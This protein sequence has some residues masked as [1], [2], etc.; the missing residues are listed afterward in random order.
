[1]CIRKRHKGSHEAV[2]PESRDIRYFKIDLMGGS[3]FGREIGRVY[4]I[5]QSQDR[6]P[7]GSRAIWESGV[8][9]GS[10]GVDEG[11]TLF[12]LIGFCILRSEHFCSTLLLMK[13]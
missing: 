13:I 6:E 9:G 3:K 4:K 10:E 1:M 8:V 2:K 12:I 7:L 11:K 5:R